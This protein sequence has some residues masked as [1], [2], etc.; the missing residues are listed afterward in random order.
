MFLC[1]LGALLIGC[2]LPPGKFE[3]LTGLK[4]FKKAL[5]FATIPESLEKRYP[6]IEFKQDFPETY[7]FKE[8]QD[9][10]WNRILVL[11]NQRNEEILTK[12][13]AKG[14]IVTRSPGYTVPT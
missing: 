2:G 1:F 10:V 9:Q 11:L 3:E 5:I 12:D 6:F 14:M 4:E 13:E 8:E 7:L